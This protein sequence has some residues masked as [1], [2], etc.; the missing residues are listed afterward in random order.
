VTTWPDPGEAFAGIA[1][2][3]GEY[4]FEAHVGSGIF[5][6]PAR[7]AINASVIR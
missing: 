7:L 2:L 4:S 5:D 1:A 6:A 3:L